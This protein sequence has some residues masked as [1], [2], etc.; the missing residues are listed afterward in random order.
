MALGKEDLLAICTPATLE[1]G[2]AY[3]HEGRV[4]ILHM[5]DK[6]IAAVVQGRSQYHVGIDL[7]DDLYA[8]CTCPYSHEG[9]CKHMI[10]VMLSIMD[11]AER[12]RETE[13]ARSIS[14]SCIPGFTY[15]TG[16]AL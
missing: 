10:A 14:A 2:L 1:R 8:V 7:K 5:S 9:Y 4:R 16:S 13:G 12:E 3:F 6:S 11:G 15:S